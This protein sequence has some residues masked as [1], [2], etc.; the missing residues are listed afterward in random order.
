MVIAAASAAFPPSSSTA[1]WRIAV[2]AA[3]RMKARSAQQELGHRRKRDSLLIA[4]KSIGESTAAQ[5][6]RILSRNGV[7]NF[8]GEHMS[9]GKRLRAGLN[10]S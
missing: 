2:P 3:G 8:S 7:R 1:G 10:L 6:A 5:A 4:E 9:P